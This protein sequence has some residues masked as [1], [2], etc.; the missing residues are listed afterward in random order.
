MKKL[1]FF[2][3]TLSGFM[4]LLFSCSKGNE[5]D[6]SSGTT[7]NST[8]MTYSANIKPILQSFCFSCHGNG[9][10]Q[11]GINFDTYAGVK[12][13]VDNGKLIGA[14]THTSGFSPMPQNTS[15]LSDCNI[16]KIQD[17]ISRGALNN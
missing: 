4:V 17:W 16:S 10:S 6:L 12:A 7:C 11:N 5:E 15:K 9:M 3:G 14:I 2:I 13:V 8:N 1:L